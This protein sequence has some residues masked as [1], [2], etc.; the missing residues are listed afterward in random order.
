MEYIHR[1]ELYVYRVPFI[2]PRG[3]ASERSGL[4]VR[5]LSDGGHQGWGEVAPLPGFSLETLD[6][7]ARATRHVVLALDQLEAPGTPDDV[8]RCMEGHPRLP[9]VQFGVSLALSRLSASIAETTL[10]RWLSDSA[11][12]FVDVNTLLSGDVDEIRE[13]VLS[14]S[15]EGF[16]VFKMKVGDNNRMG[17]ENLSSDLDRVVAARESMGTGGHLRLDANRSCGFDEALRFLHGAAACT[18]E[19]VEEPLR[20]VTRLQ[21]LASQSPVSLAGD[22]SIQEAARTTIP[23][24][25]DRMYRLGLS[26]AVLKPT[27]IGSLNR[28]R[29]LASRLTDNGIEPVLSSS[30]ETGVGLSGLVSLAASLPECTGAAG[31]DTLRFMSEGVTDHGDALHGPRIRV[32]SAEAFDVRTDSLR[33]CELP[34]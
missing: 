6:E 18:I 30:F 17:D 21:E 29:N 32:G 16:T 9:S 23:E 8:S 33:A 19:Y 24:A 7:A 34:G 11:A 10:A 27:L 15:A 28:V 20:D 1:S 12:E 14:R 13:Q 31:L 3:K 4:L 26:R 5:L 25:V 2:S 22:E